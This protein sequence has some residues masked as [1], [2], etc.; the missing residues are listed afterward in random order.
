MNEEE[1]DIVSTDHE[2]RVYE[3]SFLLVP[4]LDGASVSEETVVFRDLIIE[5]QGIIIAEGEAKERPLAYTMTK[6]IDNK[7]EKFDRAH[8][9]WIKFETTPHMAL[10]IKNA[11]DIR[12]NILRF[13]IVK[14]TREEA[15]L[16]RSIAPKKRLS[17][18]TEAKNKKEE[19]SKPISQA[20]L[21]K[22]IDALVIGE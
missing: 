14:P 21:D 11:L 4:T 12:K 5:K 2:P 7:K 22:T 10:E 15:V 1:K 17:P 8:F 6:M 18:K 16:E 19:M 13:L 20:E 9:G 3:L